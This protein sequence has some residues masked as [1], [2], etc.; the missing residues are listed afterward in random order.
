M[1]HY[2]LW[3]LFSECEYIYKYWRRC[4]VNVWSGCLQALDPNAVGFRMLIITVNS[5]VVIMVCQHVT[6]CFCAEM[7]T[8]V[9]RLF[10][11]LCHSST[12]PFSFTVGLKGYFSLKGVSAP[13]HVYTLYRP[14]HF[15]TWP[16]PF[17]CW[18]VASN[19]VHVLKLF[20]VFK[21]VF[22]LFKYTLKKQK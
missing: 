18:S 9:C 3:Q 19:N 2:S 16:Q 1:C 14:V 7:Q 8:F 6:V 17:D 10:E 20:S 21:P 15:E 4:W 5:L 22:I 11:Y 12:A 13:K